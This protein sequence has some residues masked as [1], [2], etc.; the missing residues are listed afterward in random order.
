MKMGWLFAGVFLW[1]ALGNLGILL[2]WY[3]RGKHGSLIPL[4]GGLSGIEAC[5][6]LPFPTPRHWWWMPLI[7]DLGSAHLA[8][9]MVLFLF[10]RAF[11]RNE[12]KM[13]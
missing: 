12:K 8:C 9:A 2:R 6:T 5:F 7:A 3:V 1:V 11:K 10:G 4:V 13:D